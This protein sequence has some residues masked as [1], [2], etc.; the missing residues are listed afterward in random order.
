MSTEKPAGELLNQFEQ[1]C[2]VIK[3]YDQNDYSVIKGLLNVA[4]SSSGEA[5]DVPAETLAKLN[6]YV[7]M[8]N[9]FNELNRKYFNIY[10]LEHFPIQ[11]IKSKKI[12]LKYSYIKFS[13][14]IIEKL[15]NPNQ[16][17]QIK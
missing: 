5:D 11:L 12:L 16:F 17:T 13:S 10:F 6:G 3:I 15:I 14:I 4:A 1:L 7:A 9:K 2:K 8:I